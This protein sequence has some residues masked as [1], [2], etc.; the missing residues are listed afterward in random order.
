MWELRGRVGKKC[1]KWSKSPPTTAG[2]STATP[3]Q[4]PPHSTLLHLCK[5][6]R[7]KKCASMI[8]TCETKH[9]PYI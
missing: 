9:K 6:K 5:K 4:V 8:K 2:D 7:K 3:Y 1:I